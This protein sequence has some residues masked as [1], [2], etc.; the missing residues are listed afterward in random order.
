MKNDYG[1]PHYLRRKAKPKKRV[2]IPTWAKL[3]ILKFLAYALIGT[4]IAIALQVHATVVPQS[5]P[6]AA[7]EPPQRSEPVAPA[8]VVV[9]ANVSAYTSSTD[10]TDEDPGTTASGTTPERGT[11]A[12]PSKYD[13]GTRVII[14]G[15]TYICE[16]RM[17]SRY[18]KTEHFDI[19][20]ASKSEAYR[21]GRQTLKIEIMDV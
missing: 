10:E 9:L 16:D 13:F 4:G 21:W 19:W 12:C 8:K 7:D 2:L 20:V 1:I 5:I 3:E 14:R 18:R 6:E 17:N 15:K 11:I